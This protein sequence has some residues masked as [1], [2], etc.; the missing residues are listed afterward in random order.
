MNL[1]DKTYRHLL[2]DT[3]ARV[4]R[5]FEDVDPDLAEVSLSQGTL[6]ITFLEKQRLMLTPQPSPRQLWAAFRDRAWHFDWDDMRL[7]WLDDRGQSVELLS[8]IE[9]TTRDVAKVEIHVARPK[10]A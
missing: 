2:D 10:A 1:D 3:F 5:A 8:L 6:T 7:A 9:Q 4:D